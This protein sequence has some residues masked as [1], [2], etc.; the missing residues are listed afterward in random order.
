[1]HISVSTDSN[2]R[3]CWPL[4]T[5][6]DICVKAKRCTTVCEAYSKQTSAWLSIET[7]VASIAAAPLASAAGT[8]VGSAS[9]L[10]SFHRTSFVHNQTAA[11]EVS[12]VAGRN[13]PLGL[14]IVRNLDETESAR[15]AGKA[16]HHDVDGIGVEYRLSE[17]VSQFRFTRLIWQITYE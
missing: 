15:L 3:H 7:S 13:R 4:I 6:S 10:P 2:D 17:P 9:G 1:M 12:P 8:T 5:A 14:V 16:V 11:Q